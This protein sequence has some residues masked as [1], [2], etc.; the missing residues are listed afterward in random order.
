MS[1]RVSLELA[2]ARLAA[3][4][5]GIRDLRDPHESLA[6]RVSGVEVTITNLG[7]QVLRTL[8]LDNRCITRAD[9]RLDT[10]TQRL[11]RSEKRARLRLADMVADTK[12]EL[13]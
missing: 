3:A 10:T 1:E 4:Q 7:N 13:A 11:G 12:Q 8:P 9:Q 5:D 2:A 6:G